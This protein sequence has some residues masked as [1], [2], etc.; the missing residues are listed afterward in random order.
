MGGKNMVPFESH[1]RYNKKTI[2][3]YAISVIS[4]SYDKTYANFYSP[5]DTDNFDYLSVDGTKALE[6]SLVLTSNESEAYEYENA[7]YKGRKK[8][9]PNRIKNANF[10]PDGRLI[11]Y[12]GGPLGEL[13]WN[14]RDRIQKKHDIAL[15]RLK[16]SDIGRIELCLCI[17]DGHIIELVD[18]PY[19]L[20]NLEHFV[21]DRVFFITSSRFI[22]YDKQ[23]GF[24]EYP[25]I[26]R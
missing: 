22:C 9:N 14:I 4:Q 13:W 18:F 5:V 23:L 8:P 6:I 3:P 15:K 20:E 26:Y 11:S 7:I 12:S 2:E 17:V 21:F 19:Y 1:N 16:T 24:K 25:K 10:L